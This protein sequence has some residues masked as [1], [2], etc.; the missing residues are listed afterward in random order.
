MSNWFRTSNPTMR[1]EFFERQYGI[2]SGATMT[3]NGTIG[4]S[5]LLLAITVAFGVVGYIAGNFPLTIGAAIIAFVAAITLFF[6]R[7]WAMPLSLIYAPFKGF[8]LGGISL[9]YAS[10]FVDTKY[11]GI[12]PMAMAGTLVVFGTMLLLY[13]TRIIRVTET[14]RTVVI[15]A[16]LAVC[17]FYLGTFLLSFAWPGVTQLPVFGSSPI[18]I[19]FS[20]L[21]I[22]LAAFNFALDFDLIEKGVQHGLP[23]NM[24]WYASFAL[25]ITIV[26]LYIEMLRLLSKLARR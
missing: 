8:A 4:K 16:T 11:E 21:M 17:V 6:K 12:V 20:V 24:E 19:G 2:S 13:V 14:M 15:G 7:E 23:K 5:A 26:W 9:L 22:I 10:A 18:G 1:E 3:L 25:L